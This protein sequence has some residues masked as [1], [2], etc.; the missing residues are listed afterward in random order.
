MLRLYAMNAAD[1]ELDPPGN[2]KPFAQIAFARLS[3]AGL[4]TGD[5]IEYR[6]S[7]VVA[8]FTNARHSR[9]EMMAYHHHDATW[10][11]NNRVAA[12]HSVA[13]VVNSLGWA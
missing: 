4:E 9:K 6:L 2:R 5:Q 13:T 11:A 3:L 10:V 8:S 7:F 1:T 12:P